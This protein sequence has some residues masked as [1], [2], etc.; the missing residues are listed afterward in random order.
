MENPRFSIVVHNGV[1]CEQ[2]VRRLFQL[3][4]RQDKCSKHLGELMSL[5]QQLDLDLT[6]M[7]LHFLNIGT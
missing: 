7:V 5:F 4:Q 6:E 3:A 1:Q 2:V